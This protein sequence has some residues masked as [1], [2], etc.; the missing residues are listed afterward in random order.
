MA[1]PPATAS[2]GADW[3]SPRPFGFHSPDFIPPVG[4]ASQMLA[5]AYAGCKFSFRAFNE[6]AHSNARY[7]KTMADFWAYNGTTLGGT[8]D[9]ETSYSGIG[10][11]AAGHNTGVTGLVA[12]EDGNVK[13]GE[14][15]V[16][17]AGGG[18]WHTQ[19]IGPMRSTGGYDFWGIYHAD[20]RTYREE[21]AK[22][23]PGQRYGITAYA[24]AIVTT[25]GEMIELPPMHSHHFTI[26][27]GATP[28]SW[29]DDTTCWLHG[30]GCYQY[31]HATHRNG[32][33]RCTD[34]DGG[35]ECSGQDFGNHIEL[36]EGRLLMDVMI[37]DIR[38]ADSPGL[39]WWWQVVMRTEHFGADS[40]KQPLSMI[41]MDNP[42]IYP[43]NGFPDVV[44]VSASK[45]SFFYYTGR[46]PFGGYFAGTNLHVHAAKFQ[47]AL[48]VSGSPHHLGVDALKIR[49]RKT[50][51]SV[52]VE[53]TGFADTSAL[54]QHMVRQIEAAGDRRRP[55][56]DQPSIVCEW[57]GRTQAEEK[58]LWRGQPAAPD[59]MRIDRMPV[60]SCREWSFHAGSQFSTVAFYGR[61]PEEILDEVAFAGQGGIKE[62]PG[63]Y[64]E[65]GNV[66]MWYV[67][68][69][70]RSHYTMQLFSP[71]P[72][73][74]DSVMS[75]SDQ[76]RTQIHGGTPG[77]VP[78]W[79]DTVLVA[80]TLT[81]LYIGSNP[82]LFI[83]IFALAIGLAAIVWHRKGCRSGLCTILLAAVTSVCVLVLTINLLV[84]PIETFYAYPPDAEIL[85]AR[86]QRDHGRGIAAL[87]ALAV[88]LILVS[89]TARETCRSGP[90]ASEPTPWVTYA[91][92]LLTATMAANWFVAWVSEEDATAD[93][94]HVALIQS[95]FG[96][97]L[98]RVDSGHG[99]LMLLLIAYAAATGVKH[100]W[101]LFL[102]FVALTYNI[103][104]PLSFILAGTARAPAPFGIPAFPFWI[105]CSLLALGI[106]AY[107]FGSHI[108][109]A[110]KETSL[111][112]FFTDVTATAEVSRSLMLAF[113]IKEAICSIR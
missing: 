28:P 15:T 16:D 6:M 43:N 109:S 47:R 24:N 52:L 58:W 67:A 89:A 70:H 18:T 88:V 62:R 90:N 33:G 66:H 42:A 102:P 26:Q 2:L 85:T 68:D 48:F 10:I 41:E 8:D 9:A 97:V 80:T 61:L 71:V 49:P 86:Q 106:A 95:T 35:L 38:P 50:Y 103:N 57:E 29:T 76:M 84:V 110:W 83:I 54:Y 46:M 91:L 39:V 36:L 82:V 87:L 5:A 113:L 17:A 79:M 60:A 20:F 22:L 30:E 96:G 19:R 12:S 98:L 75:R 1:N 69:D 51:E 64:P 56:P 32:D 25:L 77:L 107:E 55:H 23:L 65:H 108:S 53:E 21:E 73:A 13:V 40:T 93:A 101:T 4:G 3:A 112:D 44:F 100:W 72:D 27:P 74:V 59:K 63:E 34:E 104:V 94:A 92:V 78:T 11:T 105:L 31:A 7:C 14:C 111:S 45:D 99:F 81:A 37:N